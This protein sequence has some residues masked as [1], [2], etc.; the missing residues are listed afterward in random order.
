MKSDRKD[1]MSYIL[2]HN[3]EKGM[4]EPEIK[5]VCSILMIAGSETTAT[6]LSGV[7]YHLCLNKDALRKVTDEVRTK[8]PDENAITLTSVAQLPYL[9][10][11][12]EEGLRLYPPVPAALLR[13]TPPEGET[14]NGQ[15]VPGNVS[16]Q[17]EL[18]K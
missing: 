15:F 11:V 7:T 12:L 14:I 13:R 17:A 8:F 18:T 5:Q 9:Q 10:A 4:S 16:K 2:R 1:F 6:L 3:D